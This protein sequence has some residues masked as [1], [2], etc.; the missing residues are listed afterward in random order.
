M[1]SYRAVTPERRTT[2]RRLAWILSEVV[3][4]ATGLRERKLETN[5]FMA[6][7]R[8]ATGKLPRFEKTWAALLEAAESSMLFELVPL[9]LE[10]KSQT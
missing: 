7:P 6:C 10:P 3:R 4:G 9:S 8:T 1:A 2:N 5:I